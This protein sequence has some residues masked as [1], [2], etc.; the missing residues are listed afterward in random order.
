MSPMSARAHLRALLVLGLPLIGSHLAEIAITVTDTLMV[1]WYSATALAGLTLA[2]VLY[3]SIFVLGS[4]F[5]RAVMPIVASAAGTDDDRQVRRVT[6]MGAWLSILFGALAMPLLIWS[7]GWLLAIGQAPEVVAEAALYL[8]IRAWGLIPALIIVV[9]ISYLSSLER[10]RVILIVTLVTTAINILLNYM[11]IFGN[12]G[13][14]ELG[15][16]GAAVA[17]VTM[18]VV[19]LLALGAYAAIVTPEYALFQNPWRPD[20]DAFGRVLRLGWPIG[21]TGLAEVGLFSAASVMVGWIGARELAAH[22]IALQIASVTFMLHVGL[23]QAVTV[24]VGR[25]FGQRDGPHLRMG[26][27]VAMA[28]SFAIAGATIVLFLTVPEPLIGLFLSPDDPARAVIIPVAVTLLAMAALF[29]FVDAAQVMTLGMLRGM[30]DT[31]APMVIAAVSYWLIGAPA[32]YALAFWA[33]LGAP[34]VWLGLVVGLAC[35]GILLSWR[36]LRLSA[37]LN[38]S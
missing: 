22:G 6:R 14:P 29:Q 28:L 37:A 1:G 7:E 17:S 16:A 15:I 2:G 31:Q 8:K 10:T 12:F 18:Q 23:S 36:F 33:G 5:A 20:W 32:S 3:F 9:L 35:A 11:L 24:R 26:A 38:A 30:Q 27:L 25:A 34:G 4:G 19:G 13:A 21:L